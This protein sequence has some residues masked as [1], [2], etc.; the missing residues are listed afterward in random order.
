MCVVPACTECT[1]PYFN[2]YDVLH[3]KVE[4]GYT[5]VLQ[6]GDTNLLSLDLLTGTKI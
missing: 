6:V 1:V 5:T 3:S 4:L 2:N